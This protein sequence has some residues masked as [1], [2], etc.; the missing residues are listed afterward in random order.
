MAKSFK[1]IGTHAIG[2]LARLA[3]R[4]AVKQELRDQ[5]VRPSR[6]PAHEISER[7]R[8]YLADHPEIYE[9]AMQRAWRMELAE[10]AERIDRVNYDDQRRKPGCEFNLKRRSV[11]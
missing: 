3:A 7:A 9:E 8:A 2:I 5:D 11:G 10:Q 1:P 6:V 4:N